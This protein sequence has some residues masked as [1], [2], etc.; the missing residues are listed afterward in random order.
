M[1]SSNLS[2][3]FIVG[4]ERSGTTLLMA[5]L[6]HHPRLAVP[7]VTW[8]Y[9]RFRAY[10]HTYGDLDK[11][12]HFRTLLSEMA[13]GLK[14]PF[15][16]LDW[17]P[18]TIVDTLLARAPEQSFRGAFNA[19]LG[20]YAEAVG[21]PRWGEKTPHHLY[22]VREILEDFPN[23]RIL[24]LTR[25]GRD[26]AAEQIRSAFGPTNVVA[27]AKIWQRTQNTAATLRAELS[28]SGSW[29]DVSYESLAREPETVLR[30]VLDFLGED[31]D[32]VIFD[33]YTSTTAQR[34]AKTRDHKPLGD[35]VNTQYIGIY[36]HY[37]SAWE[38][39]VFAGLAGEGLRAGVYADIAAPIVLDDDELSLYDELDQRVRAGTLD[40]PGGHILYESGNDWLIEQREV[41][42]RAGIWS[43]ETPA[44]APNWPAEFIAG[45]RAP[46][47]W[48]RR[49][50][51][52]RR[53]HGD[54]LVL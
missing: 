31:F 35:P 50:A 22:Y 37:L 36:R 43:S 18:T 46:S 51:I 32:P 33:F 38:Q 34:R 19:L 48:K 45:Q 12:E 39:G 14:T 11:P 42:R 53:F 6:G 44:D 13:F 41:R 16:G 52:P 24:H 5:L 4:S 7:E 21:K 25:D 17:H 28:G 26:V 9:P 27:A 29:L 40:A 8:Y 54:E 15:F 3:F 47:Y 49:F 1:S 2:P 30:Q 23:A 20:T 10:L